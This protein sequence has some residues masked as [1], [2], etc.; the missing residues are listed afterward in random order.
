[1][2]LIHHGLGKTIIAVIVSVKR[3]GISHLYVKSHLLN[4][5]SKELQKT[6]SA[7]KGYFLPDSSKETKRKTEE[8][9]LTL[10]CQDSPS[11]FEKADEKSRKNRIRKALQKQRERFRLRRNSDKGMHL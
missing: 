3:F 9:K 5:K 4:E 11:T 1:M 7:I 2:W 6:K 8:V 10:S